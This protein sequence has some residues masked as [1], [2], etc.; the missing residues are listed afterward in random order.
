MGLWELFLIG[1]G[2]A[3]DAFAV[4]VANAMTSGG[5]K[6]SGALSCG[7]IFG[8][9][10]GVMP[11]IGYALGMSFADRIVAFD[12]YVALAVLSILGI[13]MIIDSKND[14]NDIQSS[15]IT[16]SLLLVQGFATSV[17]ALT[18]GISFAAL[19][20]SIVM[21]VAII[22]AV[23]FVVCITGYLTGTQAGKYIGGKTKIVGGIVLIALGIKI[24][25][26]HTLC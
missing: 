3:A 13:K 7:I 6:L 10:Q 1:L 9:F 25:I 12:H 14:N 26:Q 22:A 15:K 4:S 23:T 18:V 8:L 19:G 2:L 20:E 16:F 5:K 11:T 24:F 17:D 21:P